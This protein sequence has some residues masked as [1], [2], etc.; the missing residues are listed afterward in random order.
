VTEEM[1]NQEELAETAET[2]PVTEAPIAPK[3]SSDWMGRLGLWAGVGSIVSALTGAL[4]TRFGAWDFKFGFNLLFV[5]IGLAVFA[6]LVGLDSFR[7]RRDGQRPPKSKRLIGF[8]LG[9]AL[10][11]FIGYSASPLLSVPAIHDISTDLADPPQFRML[12][13]R[14]D[15]L[16][17]VPGADE[18]AMKDMSPQQRWEAIHREAYSDI[19]TVRINQPVA[20]V[21]EKAQRIAQ[22]RGW[23]VAI[24]DTTEGRV[25]ATA[26][27]LMFG[28]K[29]DVV[30]RVR[31]SEDGKASV[32]DMRSVSRVGI[33]DLGANARRVRAFLADLSGTVSGG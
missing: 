30:V 7:K 2:S 29:D 21:V 13:L 15:N 3:A 25:E 27:T 33:S 31:P 10:I 6:L 1:H 26:T 20:E 11:G 22:T 14:K 28:F 12:A 9:A 32:V 17:Q 19:R 8:A 5:A 23:E 4:G 18:K 24:A 16:D